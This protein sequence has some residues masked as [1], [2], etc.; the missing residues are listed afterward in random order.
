MSLLSLLD[1]VC[2]VQVST[3][4]PDPAGSPNP[5]WSNVL[6]GIPCA[7]STDREVENPDFQR[8]DSLLY[9]KLSTAQNINATTQNRIVIAGVIYAVRVGTTY[10]SNTLI[11]PDLVCT[12]K[13]VLRR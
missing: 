8:D 9:F 6:V 7:L 1:K 13:L 4:N 5:L 11:A 2:N 3:P 12:T 10:A